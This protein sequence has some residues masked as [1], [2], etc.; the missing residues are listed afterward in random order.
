MSQSDGFESGVRANRRAIVGSG[1]GLAG[2]AG[3]AAVSAPGGIAYAAAAQ[4]ATPGAASPVPGTLRVIGNGSVPLAPDAASVTV[5]VD[6]TS[7][8][9]SEAQAEAT[10][11][12]EAIREA[13]SD[14][15][16]PDEDVQTNAFA[17]NPVREYDPQTGLPGP[18]SSFQVTNTVN[19]TVRSVDDIGDLLDDVVAAGANNIYG[20]AFFTD[21]PGDAATE[22]RGLAVRDAQVKAEELADA[23]GLTLGRILA[24]SESFSPIGPVFDGAKAGGQGASAPIAPGTNLVTATIEVLF[25]LDS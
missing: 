4:E 19:V 13:I 23:A 3:L 15:G 21:E 22:A 14:R 20:I 11:M 24:I 12:M 8:N 9:L 1:L 17:V 16:I 6:V 2:V 5:G 18:V 10:T 7:E 25:E